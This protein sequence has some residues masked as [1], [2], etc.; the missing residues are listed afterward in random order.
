MTRFM[1][2]LPLA[3]CGGGQLV[4]LSLTVDFDAGSEAARSEA[5]QTP[6]AYRVALQHV[7]L[8]GDTPF[9]VMRTAGPTD[10][11]VLEFTAA[12]EDVRSLVPDGV[13]IPDESF[14]GVNL[15]I[16][17]LEMDLPFRLD[18]DGADVTRTLRIWFEGDGVH[19]PGDLTIVTDAAEGWGFGP[20]NI[21]GD[22][23]LSGLADRAAAYALPAWPDGR[24]PGTSGPFGN[25][26]FWSTVQTNSFSWIA[27]LTDAAED[28]LVRVRVADTW[29][30][31]DQDD[32][33]VYDWPSDYGEAW[34]M[35]FP[36]IL[37]E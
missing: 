22:P 32:D 16:V 24:D 18:T 28:A 6:S 3:A 17:Y 10:P 30:F 35:D 1:L 21:T 25:S 11:E 29:H 34:N 19:M 12:S 8:E 4:D 37:V 13:T 33:G 20:G 2:L 26:F 27:P 9:E 23:S 15:G 5:V 7:V 14:T 31:T 36:D